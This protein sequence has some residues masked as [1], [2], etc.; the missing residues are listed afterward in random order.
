M[1][2]KRTLATTWLR[3]A[4]TLASLALFSS[5]TQAQQVQLSYFKNYFVTG[6]YVV[7]GV[8]LAGATRTVSGSTITVA[9]T[10]NFTGVPCTNGPGLF[11]S[12]IPCSSRGGQPA[13]VIAA[14]LYWQT[15]ESTV[16]CTP[17]CG[18]SGNG[19][20]N[21][22]AN[23]FSG[24]ELGNPTVAACAPNGSGTQTNAYARVY[25]ADVLRF[26]PINNTTNVRVGNGPQTFTLTSSSPNT[27]F[28]GASL[29]VVYRLVTPGN[30]R[31][32]PLRSVVIYDGSYTGT[33]GA[34]DLDQ[35]MGGFYQAA[36][37]PAARMTHIVGNGKP[38]FKETLTVNG[39]IPSGQSGSPIDGDEGPGWD[40]DTFNYNLAANASS[41]ETKVVLSSD[42]LSWAAIITSVNVQD[43]DSDGIPDIGEQYGLNFNP[44]VRYDGIVPLASPAPPPTPATFGTCQQYPTGCLNLP[45]MGANPLVPDIFVQ[46]DWM[47]DLNGTSNPDGSQNPPHSHN[48]QIAALNMVGGVF[49]AHGINI[50]FDV[51]SDNPLTPYC[52]AANSSTIGPCNY[53]SQNSPYIVPAAYAHGGNAV[54][55]AGS[56]VCPNAVTM[57]QNP[58]T[59]CAF[60]NQSD[61]YSVLGWKFGLDAIRDGDLFLQLPQ[62]FQQNEKDTVHYALFGHALAATTPF[63][64]PEAGSIS[65]IA[66][67][68][69]GD[70]LITLGLW[71]SDN[72]AFDQVG[73]MLQQA[74]TLMHELGHNLGLSHG[75]WADTPNCMPNYASVMN[76]LYQVAGLTDAKGNENIDYS[77][78]LLLPLF[79]NDLSVKIPMGI[80]LYRVRYFGPLN[81]N[82]NSP[83][84][85]TPGQASQA[86]CTTGFPSEPG[87]SYVRLEWPTVSTPDWSNGTVPSGTKLGPLDINFDATT[88]NNPQ[89]ITNETFSDSP[90]WL[91]LNLQQVSA[92][93]NADGFSTNAELAQVGLSQLGLSQLGL[94]QLGLSQ[95]GLSQ[96]GLSQLGLSQ[97]GLSDPGTA[98]LGQDQD[99]NAQQYHASGGGV[100]P[101]GLTGTVTTTPPSP[102]NPNPGGTGNALT[103]VGDP[104]AVAFEYNVYRCNASAVPGCTP[105]VLIDSNTGTP[106]S[107]AYTDF[108]ND[109]VDAGATCP[110]IKLGVKNTCYNTNYNYA[111]KEVATLTPG[112]GG[113]ESGPSN[114]ISSEVNHL[115]VIGNITPQS[116]VYG[117]ANPGVTTNVY[118]NGSVTGDTCFY[119]D[120]ASPTAAVIPHDVVNSP[121]PVYCTGPATVSTNVGV[122]YNVAYLTF[123]PSTLTITQYPITITAVASTKTY[124][125]GTSSPSTPLTPGALP[126]GDTLTWMETYDNPNVF[127][128]LATHVMTPGP[129]ASEPSLLSNYNVTLKTISTGVIN[130][131]TPTVTATGN[132]CTYNGTP[133]AGTGSATG[134]LSGPDVLT[135]VTLS[136]SGVVNGGAA[137]G[138]TATAPTNAGAYSVTASYAGSTDYKAGT[139][140]PATITINQATPTVKATGNTCTYNGTPC[141]GTGS[142]TGVL[143]GP[144]VLTPVTFSYSGVVNGG[145]VYGPA[146]TAP[147]SAGA[148][149]VTTSYAGSTNYKPGSSTPATITINQATPIVTAIGATCTYNGSPCAGTVSATGVLSGPD[150]LMPVTPSYSGVVNGG[151]V[152]GPSATAP[153]NAG[154]YTLTASYAGS[155]NYKPG[156]STPA[157]ITIN[158]AK[159]TVT[160]G[161]PAPAAPDYGQPVTLTVSVAPPSSGEVPTGTVT[162]SFT[163]STITNYICSDGSIST[164]PCTVAVT[165]SS[166][167]YVA[168]V[169]TSNLPT[170]AENVMA[171]YSGDTNFQGETANNV[172]VTV[173]Q[174]NSAV[175]LIKPTDASTYGSTVSLTVKVVDSTGGSIGV[176]TGTVALSFKLDP[177]NPSGQLYYICLDG[178]VSAT[179]CGV[180]NQIILA[181]DPM[182]PIG[183]TATIQTTALPAGLASLSFAYPINASYSGDTNFAPSGPFGLSQTVNQLTASVTPDTNQQKVYGQP[184]PGLT[185]TLSGFLAS[186][187]VTATYTRAAGQ[188]VG[189]YPISATL[190]PSGVLGNYN[191]TYN[192]A[193]FTITTAT[194]T[195]TTQPVSYA[196]G[197]VPVPAVSTVMYTGFAYT[198]SAASVVSGTLGCVSTAMANS[199]VGVYTIG[200]SGQSAAPNYTINYVGNS[201]SITQAQLTGTSQNAAATFG[202]PI[203]PLT[204]TYSVFVNGD[205][206]GS[207]TGTLTC[208]TTAVAGS[209]AGTYPITCGGQSSTNYNIT[210]N[211]TGVLTISDTINL[212]ALSLNGT[213]YG[214][215]ASSPPTWTGTA[216]QLTNTTTET[217]SAWLG[218]AIPV[219][220]AFTTTFRFQITPASSGANS[221]GDGFAFVIQSAS[222]GNATL[223]T[224]GMGGY[225]GYFGIPNSIAIE[226][227]TYDNSQF[228]DPAGAHIGI[229]SRGTA[230][231]TTDHTP[232]TG[233]NLGGPVLAAFA[234]GNAH[235]ATITYDGS[236]TIKV[237][238]DGSATPVLTSAVAINLNTLLGLSSGPAYVGFTAATGAAQEDSDIL[239]WTW[240]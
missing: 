29:V 237:Y 146:T 214:S 220:S 155:T 101:S 229:Q 184:D 211:N 227:D 60:P 28:V 103:W 105:A 208:T 17:Q 33:P 2:T 222:T 35:T 199:P 177:S 51:G 176:P 236:S 121:Y 166:G 207:L 77:Y 142:A 156:S 9:D 120:A 82:P 182:N 216:L 186:D 111:V 193:N 162:F 178:T 85:N 110:D 37:N 36:K 144:D 74:G 54:A 135:P 4:I 189:S 62:L 89:L 30:P 148:Y 163:L 102:P 47:Y 158:Q 165:L 215:N 91:S 157:T 217:T 134:V 210:Y 78:G 115:F 14:F 183:A 118:G 19:S 80:Q 197:A 181:P 168:S 66:D 61:L 203:P 57:A 141:A 22:S 235:T 69:G 131:A 234:D 21:G 117:T 11:A 173:S 137:Y 41:V 79:E 129:T 76:Y 185:G 100:P 81:S 39:S 213:N 25:R 107:T 75:G 226:F 223:G 147:T 88:G 196:Y 113:P 205:G 64:A 201:L 92:R 45:K 238:L 94:S 98:A 38:G 53:Q 139:S 125:G 68:P 140:T 160:D 63:S 43:S 198:D 26:L 224:T 170:A 233:A 5:V 106:V 71:R 126:Y 32:A 209:P 40:V 31:I 154:A 67:H 56:L 122:T 127:T 179:A 164:T 23:A 152:Y 87:Q 42:C 192:T 109:F 18:S 153:T 86:Y 159:P 104:N 34:G 49:K 52:Q 219:S 171:K 232:A 99:V 240:N 55:E 188:N 108:V 132:T 230:Q 123:T 48:P 133:C 231:N 3:T 8:N 212:S 124:D 200:C 70:I 93:P 167:N 161:G 180:G 130:Q 145:A 13:D 72:A 20:F 44:G 73:T 15:I 96:L 24:V 12:V 83:L 194:L 84:A 65:G 187:N 191:I 206:P 128:P 221:I 95:L 190:S 174:A 7:G 239:S 16:P 175:T 90:D 195:G 116:I 97:L 58:Q 27:Q 151:A 202:A 218:S 46:V 119:T 169:T 228:D 114:T 204:A 150:V 6:D 149:S 172:S 1:A 112:V 59:P 143:S 225:I 136:Y 10:I 138:P 50:H